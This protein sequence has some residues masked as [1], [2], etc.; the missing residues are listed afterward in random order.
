MR[1]SILCVQWCQ[2][3]DLDFL[4]TEILG[5]KTKEKFKKHRWNFSYL[6][7]SYFSFQFHV[8][9]EWY[10]L[11]IQV[12]H[13]FKTTIVG[14]EV[15]IHPPPTTFGL[16]GL[17]SSYLYIFTK[18]R[19]TFPLPMCVKNIF[20]LRSDEPLLMTTDWCKLGM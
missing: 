6:Q 4:A 5:P 18:T 11:R 9:L 14:K 8:N 13:W 7:K 19:N 12:C 3:R 1:I 15:I 17:P 20:H 16:L 10:I 2:F